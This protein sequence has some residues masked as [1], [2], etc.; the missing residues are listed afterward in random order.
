MGYNHKAEQMKFEA[1]WKKIE[2]EYRAVG[3]TE[4]AIIS[5]REYDLKYFNSCRVYESH[6]QEMQSMV[7][8]EDTDCSCCNNSSSINDYLENISIGMSD[9]VDLSGTGWIDLLDNEALRK[10]ILKLK[11]RD[12]DI[13]TLLVFEE[14]S[15]P[16]IARMYGVTEAAIT[17][18]IARIRRKLQGKRQM[19]STNAGNGNASTISC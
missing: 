6:K 14:Y 12:I 7:F 1:N 11:K 9:D 19:N 15:L 13:I 17:N 10:Q 4:E 16:E 8:N 3:M 2:A 18:R 5:M